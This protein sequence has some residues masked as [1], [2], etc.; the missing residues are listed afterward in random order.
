M[1]EGAA[2]NPP[3]LAVRRPPSLTDRSVADLS[4]TPQ[5]GRTARK[6]DVGDEHALL[7]NIDANLIPIL[8]K[9]TAYPHDALGNSAG[10]GAGARS[11]VAAVRVTALRSSSCSN[12][13]AL[14]LSQVRRSWRGSPQSSG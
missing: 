14:D 4:T 11:N 2:L 13:H 5:P 10:A 1:D 3:P 9:M 8:E 7:T 6:P 12:V